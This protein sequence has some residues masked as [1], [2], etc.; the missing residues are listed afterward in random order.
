MNENAA[1]TVSVFVER[2]IPW[3]TAKVWRAL[4]EPHLIGEWLMKNDFQ[5][6][7][8]HAFQLR[9][10]WGAVD[11]QVSEIEP[12]RILAYTWKAFEVETVVT[13]TLT[14]TRAGTHLRLEQEVFGPPPT[15]AVMFRARSTA[16]R[17]SWPSWSRCVRRHLNNCG[18]Q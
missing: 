9:A 13:W 17:A 16:G 5:P 11:C 2:E 15:I 12:Q 18:A 7:L 8:G 3:P 6:V 1:E 14:P 10:D 4:T